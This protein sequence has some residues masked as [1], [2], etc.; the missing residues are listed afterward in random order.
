MMLSI[1]RI[2]GDFAIC[3]DEQQQ[4]HRIPLAALPKGADEGDIL[5]RTEEDGYQLD[6]QETG[7]KRKALSERLSRLGAGSRRSAVAQLLEQATEPV[8]ASAL[9]DKFHVSRQIIVGDIALLRASGAPVVATPRGYLMEHDADG[10]ASQDYTVACRHETSEQL[11]QELYIVVDQGATVRDVIVDHP[12]YGQLTGQLQISSRFE[13]DRF[14]K[15]LA[16]T[17]AS[18]LSQLTGGIHLHT[19]RCPDQA[20]FE[21]ITTALKK[22]GI[23]VLE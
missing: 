18:P 22:A 7:R 23:L 6:V 4:Q 9:A 2:E 19:L 21:R 13:A 10:N 14:V 12:I 1:D 15:A 17:E 8:S 3:M 11:L 16:A 20:C 5:R